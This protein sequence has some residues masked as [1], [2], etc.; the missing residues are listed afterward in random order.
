MEIMMDVV[1]AYAPQVQCEME[2]KDF[3]SELGEVMERVP[4]EIKE[5]WLEQTSMGMWVRGM[6]R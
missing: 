5:W 4:R 6:N 2:D 3:R 1:S